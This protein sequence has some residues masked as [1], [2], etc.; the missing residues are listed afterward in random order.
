MVET[1]HLKYMKKA[2]EAA[3]NCRNIKWYGVGC[4]I[5]DKGGAVL[6]TGFTGELKEPD[7][8]LRH[9]EDVAIHK[10]VIAGRDL[11][12]AVLYSTL[13]PCSIRASGKTPCVDHIIHSGIKTV[14][15]G[16][17][18]PYDPALDIKCEG[19]RVLTDAGVDVVCIEDMETQC[20]Q[21][22]VG[23]RTANA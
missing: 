11:T 4:V 19:V 8:R 22:A 21:S 3:G 16:A 18:E 14:V 12:G 1:A 9:A 7:G 15:F 2:L 6:S 10:A 23:G 5:V 17:K 20:L 13:E